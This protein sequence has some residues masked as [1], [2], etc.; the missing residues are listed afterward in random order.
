MTSAPAGNKI[1][2]QSGGDL[3]IAS[4]NATGPAT[5]VTRVGSSPLTVEEMVWSHNGR[6]LAFTETDDSQVPRRGL[7]DY[8]GPE[9]TLRMVKRAF[10]VCCSTIFDEPPSET[11]VG[12]E[13][14][15]R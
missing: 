8:L 13:L 9:A 12:R 15:N 14:P 7:P 6:V 5:G 10:P 4:V 1:A 11:C 2:F 3:Y